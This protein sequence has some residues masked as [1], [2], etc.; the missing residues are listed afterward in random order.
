MKPKG[1]GHPEINPHNYSHLISN[2]RVKNIHW[3]KDNLFNKWWKNWISTCRRL[4]PGPNLSFCIKINS[5]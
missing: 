2:K 5:K 3:R 1:K 4:K